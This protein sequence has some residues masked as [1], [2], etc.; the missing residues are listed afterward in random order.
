MPITSEENKAFRILDIYEKLSK[1]Q[2]IN[3]KWAV[4]YYKVNEK[5]IRR[6]IVD[7]NDYLSLSGKKDDQLITYSPKDRGYLIKKRNAVFFS[8]SDIYVIS[9]ILLESRAF[10]KAEMERIVNTLLCQCED[11]QAVT[12]AINNE[13]RNYKETLH[14]ENTTNFIW[15]ISQSIKQN[16]YVNVS[17][18]KQN[19]ELKE[20]KLKPL[21]LIFNEYYFYLI[22]KICG[23]DANHPAVFRVDRICSYISTNE[24]FDENK[25]Q[26]NLSE[27]HQRIQFMYSGKLMHIQFKFW[28]DSSQAVQDRIPTARI[29]SYEDKTITFE[30]E[31]YDKGIVMWLLSQREFLE[32]TSPQSLRDEMKETIEKMR[33]NYNK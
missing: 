7:L 29:V 23:I 1:G 30:A 12:N 27:Y 6:D 22:A 16:H 9:K 33:A 13:I 8:V 5:S 24:T 4:D 20:R 28:G 25:E 32:V 11:G 18:V 2:I 31:V 21:G 19:G 10:S 26:F 15:E 3:K 14:K 17:Y